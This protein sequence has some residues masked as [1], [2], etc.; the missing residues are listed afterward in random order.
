MNI[1]NKKILF[2]HSNKL[3]YCGVY[4][5]IEFLIR[6]NHYN[7]EI[8]TTV[9]D[10]KSIFKKDNLIF[11]YHYA[12]SLRYI[13]AEFINTLFLLYYIVMKKKNL[14]ITCHELPISRKYKW[15]LSNIVKY[16]YYYVNYLL[17][18]ILFKKAKQ[19]M[20]TDKD[21]YNNLIKLNKNVKFL[22]VPDINEFIIHCNKKINRDKLQANIVSYFGNISYDRGI[23]D[24]I[25][26]L[27]LSKNIKLKIIGK[28]KDDYY[29]SHIKHL[30]NQNKI[31]FNFTGFL[32]DSEICNEVS[33]IDIMFFLQINGNVS[34]S[35]TFKAFLPFKNILKVIYSD[36]SQ[37]EY[38]DVYNVLFLPKKDRFN[39]IKLSISE[40]L[41]MRLDAKKNTTN[42]LINKNDFYEKY[43]K[44]NT[45]L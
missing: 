19:V 20:Y 21:N 30:L 5:Y 8:I 18:Y 25:E 7:F 33:D 45:N 31:D 2:V 32:D 38:N 35:S 41:N 6:F 16:S 34:K 26:I 11:N 42:L 15:S 24:I 1:K 14:V 36:S 40:F 28:D 13:K 43:F 23:E 37:I 4:K 17:N 44:F 12:P 10:W 9:N 22:E 27:S 39:Y 3:S 29:Y